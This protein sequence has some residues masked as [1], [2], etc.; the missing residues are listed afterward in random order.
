MFGCIVAGRLVQTNLQQVDVNKYV[1]ELADPQAIN[2][3]VVFLLG[4]IPFEPGYAAT[5]HFHRA[6]TQ[7]WQLLGMLSNTKP[8]AI[9]RLRP[10]NTNPA[11]FPAAMMNETLSTTNQGTA[12][13]GSSATLGISIE[14]LASVEAQV[15]QLHQSTNPPTTGSLV[16]HK[17]TA[18]VDQLLPAQ[19]QAIVTPLVK[20]VMENLY[21]FVTSFIASGQSGPGANPDNQTIPIKAFETWYRNVERKLQMNPDF[22][23]QS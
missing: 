5:V 8:S 16:L 9:F 19:Q 2:H 11:P 15:A 6:E 23:N 18:A 17:P 22:L 13:P 10:G 7:T 4:T 12:A 3:L 1:F 21:N 14:P 20:K